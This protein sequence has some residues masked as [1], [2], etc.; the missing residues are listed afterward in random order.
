ME[1]QFKIYYRN[2]STTIAKAVLGLQKKN[3]SFLHL[4]LNTQYSHK[5]IT[6]LF[7][8]HQPATNRLKKYQR[9]P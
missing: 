7:Y 6:N 9:K 5:P 2:N 1:N 8:K 3:H 4:F